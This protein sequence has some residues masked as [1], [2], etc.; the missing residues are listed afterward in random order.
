[1]HKDRWNMIQYRFPQTSKLL[2]QAPEEAALSLRIETT[3]EGALTIFAKGPHGGSFLH[4][5]QRPLAEAHAFASTLVKQGTPHVIFYGVGLGHHIEAFHRLHPRIPFSIYEPNAQVAR[6]FAEKGSGEFLS[7]S[8]IRDFKVQG[9][10]EEAARFLRD[11]IDK[12]DDEIVL[13]ALPGYIELFKSDL[14]RF[15]EDLQILMQHKAGNLAVTKRFGEFWSENSLRNLKLT[16]TTPNVFQ[17]R[18]HFEGKPAI[19]ISA[20]PSLSEEIP[21]LRKIKEEGRAYLFAVGSA[22]HTLVHYD[23]LPDAVCTYDP[24]PHND[25]IF[26][27]MLEKKIR[28]VPIFFGT[29]VGGRM[30]LD[31]EGPKFH[32]LTSQDR[33]TPHFAGEYVL[34]YPVIQDA[35]TIANVTLQ[36]LAHLGCSPI[37]LAGQN[38]AFREDRQYANG[39]PYKSKGNLQNRISVPA[40]DGG[41]VQTTESYNRM[42][43]EMEQYIR[44]LHPI[45]IIN[46]TKGGALIQGAAHRSL[47]ELVESRLPQ[48]AVCSSWYKDAAVD[49][50]NVRISQAIARLNGELAAVIRLFQTLASIMQDMSSMLKQGETRGWGGIFQSFDQAFSDWKENEYSKCILIPMQRA[51]YERLYQKVEKVRLEKDDL[52]KAALILKE[53]GTFIRDSYTALE[54]IRPLYKAALEEVRPLSSELVNRGKVR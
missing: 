14:E 34:K 46:S 8:L 52:M 5:P 51:G 26:Q 50:P 40:V 33:I 24:Q 19:L 43:L 37:V 53:Y 1:M 22:I 47:F 15:N 36:L 39:I 28:T 42:R 7:S 20:G 16:L 38:L 3:F 31:Y 21:L 32:M 6:L 13:C 27:S 12:T 29:S 49:V 11:F 48:G 45:E 2:M 54:K 44:M 25:V 9:R 30:A 10:P 17:M 23:I 18:R 35:T 4:H 41:Y